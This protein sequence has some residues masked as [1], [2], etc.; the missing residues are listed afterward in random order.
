LLASAF[1]Q[2]ATFFINYILVLTFCVMPLT[3]FRFRQIF[4]QLGWYILMRPSTLR[5]A[6]LLLFFLYHSS[7]ETISLYH[8]KKA[9]MWRHPTFDYAGSAAQ[10]LLVFCL[11]LVFSL[12]ALS[13]PSTLPVAW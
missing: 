13:C 11:T 10:G 9:K 2:N 7:T 4:Q 6:R 5:E 1:P 3:L 8:K 12:M